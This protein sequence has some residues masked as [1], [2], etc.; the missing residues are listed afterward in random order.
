[1]GEHNRALRA[2]RERTP[3]RNAPG[4]HLTR[5]ELADAVNRYLWD[6]T[7]RRFD[8]DDHLIGKWERGVVRYPIREYRAALRAVLDVDTD[9][10]LD[11][12]IS[13]A[14][15]TESAFITRKL[16]ATRAELKP[17]LRNPHV[18][19]VDDE[20]GQLGRS[21]NPAGTQ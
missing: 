12:T 16:H 1:V 11:E 8:L 19:R 2:A 3:S 21:L 6:T 17:L 18:R 20:I 15:A 10:R 13:A 7:R 5:A 4:E 14:K 9:A